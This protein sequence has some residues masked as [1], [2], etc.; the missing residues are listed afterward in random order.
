[1][2]KHHKSLDKYYGNWVIDI[3]IEITM[4]SDFGDEI[5]NSLN[6]FLKRE[7]DIREHKI[8]E[9]VYSKTPYDNKC[10]AGRTQ[11]EH[12]PKETI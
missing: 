12:E 3:Q 11:D 6:N 2:S 7:S 8:K 5:S 1:M 10:K 9:V 4:D